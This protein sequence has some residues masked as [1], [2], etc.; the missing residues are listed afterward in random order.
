[1]FKGNCAE[2]TAKKSG[3]SRE[4]QDAYAINSYTRSKAAWE[5]G[6]LAKEVV[7]VSIPQKGVILLITAP[8]LYEDTF[9]YLKSESL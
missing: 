2:N 8:Q 7:P 3:F 9:I 5:S 1:M 4:E 6:I